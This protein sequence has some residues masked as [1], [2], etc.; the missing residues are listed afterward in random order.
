MP[1]APGN[2][3][4]S[5]APYM[6]YVAKCKWPDMFPAIVHEDGTSRV[7]TVNAQ[8]HPELFELL[9]RWYNETGCPL[10]VNTSLNI[11]GQPIV[12]SVKDAEDFSEYYGVDVHTHDDE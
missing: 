6:Q 4:I 7:Q 2:P 1:K 5:N 10:L 9:T 12:D 3:P 11:K 8:Q